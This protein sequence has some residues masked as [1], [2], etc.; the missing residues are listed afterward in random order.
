MREP[1]SSGSI[2]SDYGLDDRAIEVR[3][4]AGAKDFA[5][6]ICVQTGSGAHP[7]SCTMCTG[8]PFTGGKARPG[9]D[10]DHSP[11]SS[12]EVVSE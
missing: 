2:V 1:G 9:R 11:V 6:S 8:G 7:A 4:P 3:S 10:A 12:A 5:S